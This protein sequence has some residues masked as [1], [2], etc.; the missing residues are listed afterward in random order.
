MYE[1]IYLELYKKDLQSTLDYIS[2]VKLKGNYRKA[3]FGNYYIF[4]E[5]DE[6]DK[7]VKIKRLVYSRMNMKLIF[8]YI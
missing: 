4:F 8:S 7:I 5:I 6:T 3:K 2:N 1:L